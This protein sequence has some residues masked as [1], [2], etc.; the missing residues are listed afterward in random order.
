MV[1]NPYAGDMR[2]GFDPWVGKNPQRRKWQPTP[3]FLPGES[4]GQRSLGDYSPYGHRESDMTEAA[5]HAHILGPTPLPYLLAQKEAKD[6]ILKIE[7]SMSIFL[8]QVHSRMK[9]N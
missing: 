6:C 3:V 2:H 1:K 4:H 5:W 8:E 7:P 9:G